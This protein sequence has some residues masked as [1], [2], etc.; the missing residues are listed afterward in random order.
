MV[1]LSSYFWSYFNV[2]RKKHAFV[3][4]HVFIM[5]HSLHHQAYRHPLRPRSRCRC[6]YLWKPV[7][8]PWTSF[9][10]GKALASVSLFYVNVYCAC[11]SDFP[12]AITPTIN[13][14]Y[15]RNV[16][17]RFENKELRQEFGKLWLNQNSDSGLL[18]NIYGLSSV[19]STAS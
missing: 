13:I 7:Y 3:C 17:N 6:H 2:V 10:T 16:L 18:H 19:Q 1:M 4:L 12:T 15:E 5:A 8:V 11:L 9:F 14:F